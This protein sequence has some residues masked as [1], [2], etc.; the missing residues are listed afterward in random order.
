MSDRPAFPRD[1]FAITPSN[2]TEYPQDTAVWVGVS[3]DVVVTTAIGTQLT[4]TAVA[5]GT[6]IPVMVKQVRAT[7]TTASGLIGLR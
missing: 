6:V 7:G 1:G 5:A 4:F 3:G 2:S